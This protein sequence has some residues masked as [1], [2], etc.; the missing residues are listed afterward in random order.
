MKWFGTPHHLGSVTSQINDLQISQKQPFDTLSTPL[1]LQIKRVE[2]S[3]S[4][5]YNFWKRSILFPSTV[6]PTGRQICA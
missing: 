2:T 6:L 4:V 5:P 1:R 3:A